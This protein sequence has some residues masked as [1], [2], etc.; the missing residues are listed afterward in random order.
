M[1]LFLAF[2]ITL[3]SAAIFYVVNR[4]NGDGFFG[5]A[6]YVLSLLNFI[7][8]S[9]IPPDAASVFQG[10]L[11]IAIFE[12][13]SSYWENSLTVLRISVL[14]N[15]FEKNSHGRIQ[16]S[17]NERTSDANV[18]AWG[19]ILVFDKNFSDSLWLWKHR[20][21]DFKIAREVC[22]RNIFEVL[23]RCSSEYIV[24][25]RT[26]IRVGYIRD[27]IKGTSE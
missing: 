12:I 1:S 16:G 3:F 14:A 22:P 27:H 11:V 13:T 9:S 5:I 21:T 17:L 24:S 25:L 26:V 4:K 20:F 10:S 18:P 2:L 6:I 19:Q 15:F 7:L 23:W 8:I